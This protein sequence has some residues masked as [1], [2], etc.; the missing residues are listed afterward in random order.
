MTKRA[1][2]SLYVIGERL[3]TTLC[4]LLD[5]KTDRD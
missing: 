5:F 4:Q 2:L 3:V 1:R